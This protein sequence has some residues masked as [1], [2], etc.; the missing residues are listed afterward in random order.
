MNTIYAGTEDSALNI[1][2]PVNGSTVGAPL[3]ANSSGNLASGI[4]NTEVNG[5]STLT[6]TSTT[7][8]VMTGQTITPA[9]GT[10]LVWYSNT[11]T[12]PSLGATVT[13]TI[14]VNGSQLTHSERH[15][16]V[17]VT[18]VLGLGGTSDG[19]LA[20]Q[21]LCTVTGSQAID[22]RW[23]TSTGTAS[24]FQRALNILRVS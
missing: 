24:A 9:A 19:V 7:F 6:T 1:G 17:S 16:Q 10:Y 13:A 23:K 11:V 2:E 21:G 12:C 18:G 22:V 3:S 14:F 5:T 15:F 4:S 8:V 20:A